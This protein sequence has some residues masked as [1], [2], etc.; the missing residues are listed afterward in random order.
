MRLFDYFK[1]V[2]ICDHLCLFFRCQLEHEVVGETITV[3]FDLFIKALSC[4]AIV[5]CQVRIQHHI[6]T[7]DKKDGVFN[8][9]AGYK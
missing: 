4:Y 3:T 9:F 1:V 6:L 7:S 2:A 8:S 5:Y